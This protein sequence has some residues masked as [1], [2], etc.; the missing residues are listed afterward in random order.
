MNY[1]IRIIAGE[2]RGRRIDVK[3]HPALRPMSDRARGALFNILV[4][5]IPDR[6]FFD[7][8]AGR[9]AVGLEALSRSAK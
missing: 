4:K 5:D 7:I 2:L 6:P 3:L 9:G 1:R 8:F